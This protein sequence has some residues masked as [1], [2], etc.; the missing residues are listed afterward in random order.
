M[1]VPVVAIFI[2]IFIAGCEGTNKQPISFN[3]KRHV[4]MGVGCDTCHIFVKE[5]SF[6]GLPDIE[7]CLI[8]HAA[9]ITK[10]PEEEKIRDFK[11]RGI[12]LRWTRLTDLPGHVY[13]SHRRHVGIA[14]LDCRG[15]HGNIAETTRPPRKAL[16]SLTMN[17]CIGCHKNRNAKTDCIYCHR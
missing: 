15:C 7:R 12:E 5:Q 9:A 4:D 3:H 1:K 6:A 13:F 8:C 14:G 17:D 10:S 11:K 2:V 16:M